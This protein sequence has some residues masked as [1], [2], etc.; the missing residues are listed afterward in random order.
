MKR[1]ETKYFGLDLKI[2]IRIY[3]DLILRFANLMTLGFYIIRP[4]DI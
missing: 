3:C 1:V 4:Y 2:S